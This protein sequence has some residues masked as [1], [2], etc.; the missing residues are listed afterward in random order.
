MHK[1]IFGDTN[2]FEEFLPIVDVDWLALADCTSATLVI[3]AATIRELNAH[4]DGANRGRLK[5]KAAAALI[6]LKKYKALAGRP[7]I[8]D[9]VF[10][11]FRPQEPLINFADYHLDPTKNDDRLLA[12]AIEFG[13]EKGLPRESILIATGDWGL[14]L[15]ADCQPSV[16]PLPLP[17]K[18]RLAPELDDEQKQTKD[19]QQR[20]QRLQGASPDLLLRFADG[21]VF[22]KLHLSML[23]PEKDVSLKDLLQQ[24]RSQR[25]FLQHTTPQ[26]IAGWKFSLATPEDIENYNKSLEAYF[27]SFERWLENER[28]VKEW[29]ALTAKVQLQVENHGGAPGRGVHVDIHFPDGFSV[30]AAA[31]V[32]KSPDRPKAPLSPN[33]QLIANV[34]YAT[35]FSSSYLL[36][37]RLY[38]PR[39]DSLVRT[40]AHLSFIKKT[41]SYRVRFEVTELKHTLVQAL[42]PLYIHFAEFGEARGFELAYQIVASNYPE[43]FKDTL[44]IEVSTA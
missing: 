32:P 33:E 2:L 17:D 31:D 38:N 12:S 19:L 13:L 3:P 24:E 4:K 30:I 14:E 34:K 35:S 25:P 18:Y 9:N 16:T 44:E 22:T 23:L 10:L 5:R 29:H 43:P 11:E 21:N 1:Y 36:P 37:P 15:K 41:N 26:L 6:Q 42:P 40:N 8:R 7:Q 20:L 27:N 28:I 39:A